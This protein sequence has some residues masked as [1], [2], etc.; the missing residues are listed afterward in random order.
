NCKSGGPYKID[1]RNRMI[2]KHGTM[3]AKK[4]SPA[5]FPS[6]LSSRPSAPPT[7]PIH[8]AVVFDIFTLR[9]RKNVSGLSSQPRM[10]LT[11]ISSRPQPPSS[12]Y[13]NTAISCGLAH[14]HPRLHTP[15]TILLS[16]IREPPVFQSPLKPSRHHSEQQVLREFRPDER[17]TIS[18]QVSY[19][20][21][22][23]PP[24]LQTCGISDNVF[25]YT[26]QQHGYQ[27]YEQQT[28]IIHPVNHVVVVQQLPTE[29]PGQMLCP[30]CQTTVLSQTEYK[31][32]MLTWLICGILGFF[33]CWFCC[34]IPFFVDACKDVEHTCPVCRTVLHVHKRR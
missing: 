11:K 14:P 13:T 20:P 22:P 27:Y 15:P 6:P 29:A 19:L 3:V 33:L 31:N 30:R 4:S 10:R 23:L 12:V 17:S 21:A 28:Q 25:S 1:T 9:S 8:T 24:G 5:P 16:R 18:P 7:P 32:G 2:R 26:V 34:F